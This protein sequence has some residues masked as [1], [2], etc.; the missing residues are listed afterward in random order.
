M[1]MTGGGKPSLIQMAKGI[2]LMLSPKFGYALRLNATD[3]QAKDFVA[4]V[5]HREL[6]E[7][8]ASK[9]K[10]NDFLDILASVAT[11]A[12]GNALNDVVKDEEE[13]DK[14]S[15]L[16]GNVDKLSSYNWSPDEAELFVVSQAIG[17]FF[18]AVD[19]T[20]T[21]LSLVMH[22]I[23]LDQDVQDKLFAEVQV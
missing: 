2:V 9:A 8:K 16:K 3:E 22:F 14:D 11:E 1:R 20:S 4:D 12:G 10:K 19:T 15:E 17:L 7:R 13:F 5:I 21:A 18:A 23:S 6:K